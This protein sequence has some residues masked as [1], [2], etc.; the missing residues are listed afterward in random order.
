V[1]I[2]TDKEM[3]EIAV[4]KAISASELS[5]R[6]IEDLAGVSKTHL[7]ELA[8]PRGRRASLETLFKLADFFEISYRFEGPKKK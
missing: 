2:I 1:A 8:N 7:H 4:Q 5:L 6:K 3:L